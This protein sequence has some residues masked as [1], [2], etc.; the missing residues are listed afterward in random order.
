M[1]MGG[2]SPQCEALVG[3]DGPSVLLL[4]GCSTHGAELVPVATWHGRA[5][6]MP[7]AVAR[8]RAPVPAEEW[9]VW[10]LVRDV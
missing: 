7:G 6:A 8:A 2:G 3:M 4:P 9:G 10:W 5:G 1:G